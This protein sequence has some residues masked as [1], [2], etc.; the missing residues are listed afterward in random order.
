M[1]TARRPTQ[2]PSIPIH[3]VLAAVLAVPSRHAQALQH[4]RHNL[5]KDLP[6]P[7]KKINVM[8]VQSQRHHCPTTT[9]RLPNH[10]AMSTQSQRHDCPTTTPSLPNHNAMTA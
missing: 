7:P 5:R 3:T 8:N 6:P 9:S 2:A 4:A 10:N 1:N